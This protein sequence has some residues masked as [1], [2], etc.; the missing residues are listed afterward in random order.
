[1]GNLRR[2]VGIVR[3]VLGLPCVV[4]FNRF[5]DDTD[6]ELELARRLLA[7]GG[8]EALVSEH[9][10]RGWAGAQDLARWAEALPAGTETRFPYPAEAPLAEKLDALARRVYGAVGIELEPKAFDEIA[11][12]EAKGFGALPVCVAKTQLSFTTDPAA[13]GAPQ[14]H[15]VRI[16]EVRLS[17]G[18]GFVVAFAGDILTMPGLPARPRAETIALSPDGRITGLD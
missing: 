16:R 10:A 13:R 11:W 3:D 2:H 18:A 8:V 15:L 12:L 5:A 14:G 4:C 7:G 6:A 1:M 9:W 17:A